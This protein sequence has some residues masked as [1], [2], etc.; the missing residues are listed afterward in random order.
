MQ[1]SNFRERIQKTYTKKDLEKA[2]GLKNKAQL[3]KR[4]NKLVEIYRV[5]MKKFQKNAGESERAAYSFNGLAFDILC[6]LLNNF[7]DEKLPKVIMDDNVKVRKEAIKNIDIEQYI[8]FIKGIKDDIDKIKFKPLRLHL[9]AQK[10]YQDVKKV[11]DSGNKINE[12]LQLASEVMNQLS[13]DKQVE[14]SN[15]ISLAIH[16]TIYSMFAEGK[17]NE[18][19]IEHNQT[20]ESSS[21]HDFRFNYLLNQFNDDVIT[22]DIEEKA[23]YIYE[24]DEQLD[25][26]L[27]D[28]LNSV[29]RAADSWGMRNAKPHHRTKNFRDIEYFFTIDISKMI[30]KSLNNQKN[31]SKQTKRYDFDNKI[32]V[33]NNNINKFNEDEQIRKHLLELRKR[34]DFHSAAILDKKNEIEVENEMFQYFMDDMHQ[35]VTLVDRYINKEQHYNKIKDGYINEY[36]TFYEAYKNEVH[37]PQTDETNIPMILLMKRFKDKLLRRRKR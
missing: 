3:Q 25:W 29:Q 16:E 12:K 6:V 36:K 23:Y 13:I 28:I 8:S 7:S 10:S 15:R 33:I 17:Y 22:E 31:L 19:I 1:E 35:V 21:L 9:Y 5:D 27:V 14:L 30:D 11:L 34:L 18:R 26:L 24:K 20:S 32:E 4:I 2:L 37:T